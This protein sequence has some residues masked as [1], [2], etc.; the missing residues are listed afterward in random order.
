LFPRGEGDEGQFPLGRFPDVALLVNSLS[1]TE[2]GGRD[3]C[4]GVRRGCHAEET[5]EFD[6]EGRLS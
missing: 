3:F 6:Y 5:F 1:S 2:G 4:E